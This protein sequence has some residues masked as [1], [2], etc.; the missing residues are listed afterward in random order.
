MTE[1]PRTSPEQV[2]S[3]RRLSLMLQHPQ[4]YFERRTERL[5]MESPQHHRVHV[6]QQTRIPT[7]R[8]DEEQQH[9][10][11]VLVSLGLFSKARLPDLVAR[12]AE[13][14]A[15][16]VLTQSQRA[17]VLAATATPKHI[18]RHLDPGTDSAE[19]SERARGD[20]HSAYN[21]G[22]MVLRAVAR[23]IQSSE[24]AALKIREELLLDLSPD[25][26]PNEEA[27]GLSID[28]AFLQETE[29]MC[30]TTH[31]LALLEATPGDVV[32]LSHEYSASASFAHDDKRDD[33]GKPTLEV[34]V[35]LDD[36]SRFFRSA[37]RPVADWTLT[38]YL[39]VL[40]WFGMTT[41]TWTQVNGNAN[42]CESLHL[43]HDV[44]AGTSIVRMYWSKVEWIA[45]A[46]DS[47]LDLTPSECSTAVL[48]QNARRL[49]VTDRG[50]L[51]V[52]VQ[53][54]KQGSIA[55]AGLLALFLAFASGYLVRHNPAI[56]KLGSSAL[57][58]GVP[59]ALTGVLAQHRAGFPGWMLR[60]PRILMTG[61]AIL[62]GALGTS[63]SL[64]NS[65]LTVVLAWATFAVATFVALVNAYVALGPRLP[66]K[67]DQ[68]DREAIRK[69]Q[70]R[71]RA[72]AGIAF[73]AAILLTAW[74]VVAVATAQNLDILSL[75]FIYHF[76]VEVPTGTLSEVADAAQSAWT[77]LRYASSGPGL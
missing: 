18:R 13:G 19:V 58:I 40:A 75:E 53:P 8:G 42:H 57:I 67:A 52:E 32:M 31:V 71:S 10:R 12:D 47:D 64:G 24:E 23:M 22:Q 66:S 14:R 70:W 9:P 49:H 76:W 68:I 74:L 33:P 15:L 6:W 44:A 16:P 29:D 46:E 11:Q 21:I 17:A 27:W 28:Q 55:V 1:E 41:T 65:A 7:A 56:P 43:I 62:A 39:R 35:W 5:E 77:T 50:R 2:R 36:N 51:Y 38:H 48:S 59:A 4:A 45:G 20:K 34:M 37:V 63:A 61:L 72:A 3:I 25:R 60:G 26:T 54:S 69:R 73:P 30:R